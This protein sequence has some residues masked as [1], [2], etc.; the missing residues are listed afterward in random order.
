[1]R[2]T[3]SRG[4]ALIAKALVAGFVGTIA[5]SAVAAPIP[6]VNSV[7]DLIN[8]NAGDPTDGVADGGVFIDGIRFYDFQYTDS[9]TDGGTPPTAAQVEVQ[10]APGPSG[11]SG[12]EFSFNWVAANDADMVSTIRY[13]VQSPGPINVVGLFFDGDVP[14]GASSP[15]T[16][17]QV[18]ETVRDL[19]GNVLGV[20]GVFDD[21]T[22]PGTESNANSLTLAPPQTDLDLSKAIRVNAEG[23]GVADISIVDNTFQIIPEPSTAAL[24][25][26]G[27]G[28][29]LTRRRRVR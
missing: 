9:G 24:L 21:G 20:L 19:N 3:S 25:A 15:G 5:A 26:L 17:A 8:M 7:Q 16:F 4:H 13:K 6:G 29:V 11:T 18:T 23:G 27:L 2:C 12:L 1:M 28:A 10:T 22:G 14:A